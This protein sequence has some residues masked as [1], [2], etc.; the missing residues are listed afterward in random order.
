MTWNCEKWSKKYQKFF[1]LG[2]V[3]LINWLK[4]AKI[5][6]AGIRNSATLKKPD[7]TNWLKIAKIG[8]EGIRNSATFKK[9][10]VTNWLKI[11]KIGPE[12]IR[13]SATLD[14]FVW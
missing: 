9:P 13:N 5:G 4:I 11:A 8:L 12:G 10:D 14:K 3:C 2:R 6:L 7:V 1:Y